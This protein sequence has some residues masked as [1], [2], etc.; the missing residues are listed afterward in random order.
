[1][2][3]ASRSV[4][5]EWPSGAFVGRTVPKTKLY[6]QGKVDTSTRQAI[7]EE[8]SQIEWAYKLAEVSIGLPGTEDVPEIQVFRVASKGDSVGD[9][10]LAAID[11]SVPSPIIFEVLRE[12]PWGQELR[13][14][15]AFRPADHGASR[16]PEYFTTGW[17]SVATRKQGLPTAIDLAQLY[18]AL[19]QPLLPLPLRRGESM[20]EA[21]ARIG[22][23]RRLER[24]ITS[25][26]KRMDREKQFKRQVE[27]RRELRRMQAE[28]E[29][30]TAVER[31]TGER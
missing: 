14:T 22:A 18:R 30:V 25:L 3:T 15:A 12:T 17:L 5:F 1:M 9:R 13:T 6:E 28:L 2:S 23:S 11:R 21:T 29:N 16:Q 20:S 8:V 4:V 19:L 7:V 26:Q 27:M 10:A 31:S 24:D